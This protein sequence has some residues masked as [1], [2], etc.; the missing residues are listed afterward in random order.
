MSYLSFSMVSPWTPVRQVLPTWTSMQQMPPLNSGLAGVSYLDASMV[1]ISPECQYSRFSSL[2]QMPVQTCIFH[3]GVSTAG[4]S[5]GLQPV[6]QESHLNVTYQQL[7]E[8]S[9]SNA[10][11]LGIYSSVLNGQC[12]IWCKQ[13]AYQIVED[14]LLVSSH[15]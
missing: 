3:L 1:D 12:S 9:T 14:G 8:A 2:R 6:L 13:K 7:P 4:S 15:T 11:G 10:E 5:P